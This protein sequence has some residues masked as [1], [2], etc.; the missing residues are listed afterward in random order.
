MQDE[1]AQPWRNHPELQG[2]FHIECPDDIQVIVHDGGPYFSNCAPEVV[3]VRVAG[4]AGGVYTGT[5]LNEPKNLRHVTEGSQISFIVPRGG[6]HPLLA[7]PDYL[8]ERS[9]WRLVAPCKCGLTELFDPPSRLLASTFPSITAEEIA[10]GFVFT[11]RCGWCG[12]TVAV[13]MKRT[14]WPWDNSMR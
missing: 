2:K 10:R 13:R 7:R 14:A 6:D 11:T 5:V 1:S 8:Q 3:W 12:Q 4:F 9:G